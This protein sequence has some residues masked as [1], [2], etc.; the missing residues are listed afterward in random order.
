MFA[1]EI[2]RITVAQ[3]CTYIIHVQVVFILWSGCN[4]SFKLTVFRYV[5][6]NSLQHRKRDEKLK[7]ELRKASEEKETLL[8]K[9]AAKD[10]KG[11]RS[12]RES[13]ISSDKVHVEE[14]MGPS[15]CPDT[16]FQTLVSAS[17]NILWHLI[18]VVVQN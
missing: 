9:G 5:Y 14:P 17:N 3:S 18:S 7:D 11:S 16:V 10:E 12:R 4:G 6:C 8:G 2:N 15:I 1:N 13:S